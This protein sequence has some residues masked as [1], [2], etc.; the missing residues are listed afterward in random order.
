MPKGVRAVSYT[1]LDVYT[2]QITGK[3]KRKEEGL[4]GEILRLKDELAKKEAEITRIKK[5][6]QEALNSVRS[7]YESK[8][9]VLQQDKQRAERWEKAA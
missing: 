3:T 2:R 6:A 7:R 4:K 1:H 5:E 9:Y 8:V